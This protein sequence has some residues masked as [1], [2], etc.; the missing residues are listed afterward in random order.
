[1]SIIWR[2][3]IGSIRL[4]CNGR[5]APLRKR[6]TAVL[7]T[8]KDGRIKHGAGDGHFGTTQEAAGV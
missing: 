8:A 7:Y 2:L 6:R 4:D 1:M 5:Y 3:K